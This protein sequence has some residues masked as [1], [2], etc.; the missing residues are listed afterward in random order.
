MWTRSRHARTTRFHVEALNGTRDPIFHEFYFKLI[1]ERTNPTILKK[2]GSKSDLTREM[3][4]RAQLIWLSILRFRQTCD[5]FIS[6]C[7]GSKTKSGTFFVRFIFETNFLEFCFNYWIDML[8]R[9][10]IFSPTNRSIFLNIVFFCD[11]K[12][13]ASFGFVNSFKGRFLNGCRFG[14]SL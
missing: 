5:I 11:K 1:T 4:Q 14:G 12:Y 6:L 13:W 10:I 7:F 3:K 8:C 2:F 9:K